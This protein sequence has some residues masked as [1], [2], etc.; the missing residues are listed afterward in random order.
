MKRI[1]LL[2]GEAVVRLLV[3]NN[4]PNSSKELASVLHDFEQ[5]TNDK[6]EDTL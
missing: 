4:M 5:T 6:G 2:I 1:I 3:A